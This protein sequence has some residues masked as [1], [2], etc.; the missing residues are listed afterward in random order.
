MNQH[1]R[2]KEMGITPGNCTI[3]KHSTHN[4]S[5]LFSDVIGTTAAYISNDDAPIMADA[6]NTM[7]THGHTPSEMVEI[8]REL[9]EVLSD[10]CL[11]GCPDE[12]DGDFGSG[13][14]PIQRGKTALTK[15]EDFQ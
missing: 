4:K 6:L 7:N 1:P 15:T 3:S 8:I 13:T 12:K 10:I 14:S 2:A 11:V 9:R 5:Y